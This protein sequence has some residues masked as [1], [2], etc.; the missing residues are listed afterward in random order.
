[1]DPFHAIP[2][3]PPPE[4]WPGCRGSEEALG[5]IAHWLT[6]V[7]IDCSELGVAESLSAAAWLK[8]ELARVVPSIQA[9]LACL[10]GPVWCP[11]SI[12]E[13]HRT[14]MDRWPEPG[15]D[16]TR[17]RF[18]A[19]LEG[20]LSGPPLDSVSAWSLWIP[21]TD[22]TFV[23][24]DGL[25]PAHSVVEAQGLLSVTQALEKGLLGSTQAP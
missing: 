19:N 16:E 12:E 17:R 14:A 23:V 22:G 10:D 21:T 2:P 4:A 18:V 3:L 25:E 5:R 13:I 8:P 7:G 6:Q 9:W 24:Y 20:G 15:E 1:M 11:R